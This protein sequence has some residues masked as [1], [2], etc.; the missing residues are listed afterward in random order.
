MLTSSFLTTQAATSS[1]C[2]RG[3]QLASA[4][5]RLSVQSLTDRVIMRLAF[6]DYLY[7]NGQ[8]Y[9]RALD[10]FRL[11]R[12]VELG[13]YPQLLPTLTFS[14]IGEVL[15]FEDILIGFDK[16]HPEHTVRETTNR[17]LANALYQEFKLEIFRN[18]FPD[19]VEDVVRSFAASVGEMSA[20]AGGRNQDLLKLHRTLRAADLFNDHPQ[21]LISMREPAV[22][23]AL[24]LHDEGKDFAARE[25][26]QMVSASIYISN[27]ER[28]HPQIR[29]IANDNRADV[30]S[31]RPG[32]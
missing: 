9:E 4:S 1:Y 28:C 24:S 2:R 10:D 11:D 5:V 3:F 27:P 20:R 32:F 18:Q 23:L 14:E 29:N 22:N 15:Q 13:I 16:L 31:S 21:A 30:P 8:A 7:N 12:S 26:M 6:E 19:T 25:L 17:R